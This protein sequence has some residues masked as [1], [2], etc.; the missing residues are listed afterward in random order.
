MCCW[1]TRFSSRTIPSRS[2]RCAPTLRWRR[3]TP[4]PCCAR[5]ATPWPLFDAMLAAGEEEL[6]AALDRHRPRFVVL[7]EDSFN[8]LSKMCLE[9]SRAAACRMSR[10][11]A[12]ERRHRPRR[13][14][15]RDGPP[16]AV[17]RSRASS[18]PSSAK[19]T[20]PCA[21]CS[22]P[23]PAAPTSRSRPCP[24]WPSRIRRPR[25]ECAA[26]PSG[27]RTAAGSL[28][29]PGLGPPGR[30][31]LP[32]RLD[33]RPR[34]LQPQPGHHPRLP[35]PLQLVRQADLGPALRHALARQRRRRDGAGAADPRPDDL[36]EWSLGDECD[37]DAGTGRASLLTNGSFEQPAVPA[38]SYMTF[39]NGETFSGW[40]VIGI[41]QRGAVEH[42]LLV[43]AGASTTIAFINGHPPGD[44]SNF[45]DNASCGRRCRRPTSPRRQNVKCLTQ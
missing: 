9:H 17:L 32:R 43:A 34:L 2:R 27:R 28:P 18:T 45:L 33:A 14:L 21:S 13:R 8:F 12:R 25:T 5:P 10:H 29:L 16:A 26:R 4:P 36:L 7:Y 30:R 31:A 22:T 24:V 37:P 35:V 11:G 20:T 6:A 19:R 3:S 23:S 44:G 38:G 40:T 41:R 15:G 42:H 39:A 1:P